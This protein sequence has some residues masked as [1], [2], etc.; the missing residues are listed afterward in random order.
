MI[1]KKKHSA[2][3]L[4]YDCTH[5]ARRFFIFAVVCT[6]ITIAAN[7][8][9]P[10]ITA[11]T[12]DFVLS[13]DASSVSPILMSVS[14]LLGDRQFYLSNLWVLAVV[15][16]F[17]A[18]VNGFA[19][20]F[21]SRSMAIASESTAKT[22]KD[23]LYVHIGDLPFDYHK[24]TMTGDLI[25]RCTSDVDTVRR[26]VYNQMME[27]VRS[28]LLVVLS[29]SLMLSIN[30]SLALI[31]II[32]IPFIMAFSFG[33]FKKVIKCFTESDEAEGKLSE[34]V[35]ENVSGVRVV[36]AFGQQLAESEK[37]DRCNVKYRDV[38]TKLNKLL[39][40][41]WGF[42]DSL[43][44]LQIAVTMIASIVMAVKGEISLGTV[45]IFNT[46][47]NMLIWPTRNL[48]R[49]LSDMGKS[50]V[51]LERLGEILDAKTEQEPGKALAPAISGKIEFKHVCFGYD[52][53]N[54]VLND[55]SFTVERGQTIGILGSTGSGKTSLV[56]LL[57]R[58]YEC[59]K[60]EVDI[61]GVNV[62]D[63]ERHHLRASIGIVMQE[64]FLYSRTIAENIKFGSPDATDEQMFECAKF[65]S[66]HD[67]I[68][69]FEN[70]Y[71]TIVGERGVT[72]SGGEKQRVAIA[73]MLLQNTPIL[74]F[75][76]SMSAV[77]AET[78]AAIR[79]ALQKRRVGVTTFIISH[80]IQTLC[81]SDFIIVL[82]NG[83]LTEKGT[84]SE[85][86]NKP[87]LYRRI[88]EIQSVF[89][90]RQGE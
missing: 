60:G 34:T 15:I 32:I 71:D 81:E 82:E 74:I 40:M 26:F 44:Y 50:K 17:V 30:V 59:T 63:I 85:L 70:G 76:D 38:T 65:A 72:L 33:Y 2:F 25:Q 29:F 86:L 16:I 48:G 13:N 64:P 7:F 87:G 35:N 89:A 23:K 69:S 56:H 83:R 28:I 54:D 24:H 78:D 52:Y 49:I 41:Y 46:Y 73:R 6:V 42:S 27:L 43:G 45:L 67:T 62:N 39:G 5:G 77:D 4:L 61:D 80:R 18:V 10:L 58:L 37:F 53:Y 51:S 55:I 57:Q 31:S 75:D 11:F 20:F 90:E 22:L 9:T 66:V 12:V 14:K 3:H 47:V 36:R 79:A 84:H 1:L 88:A 68:M 21:N 19:R 8:I